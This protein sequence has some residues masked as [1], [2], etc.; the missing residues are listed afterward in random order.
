MRQMPL[1]LHK[2]FPNH[3]VGITY[4][5]KKSILPH[6][7]VCP[8]IAIGAL[9]NLETKRRRG[10]L[11]V[12]FWRYLDW[13]L[14]LKPYTYQVVLPSTFCSE[15]GEGRCPPLWADGWVRQMPLHLH[16][17]FPNHIHSITNFDKI[18]TTG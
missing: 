12:I 13:H 10:N 3:S 2:P 6:H 14:V 7:P 16:K 9:L 17:P 18:H 8:P 4:F 5:N 11:I 15:K 1:H